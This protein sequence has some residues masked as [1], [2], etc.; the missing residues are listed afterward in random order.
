MSEN[1]ETAKTVSA[2]IRARRSTRHFTGAVPPV[3]DMDE[4]LQSAILAPF[5]GETGIPLKEIRKVFVF[6]QGTQSMN[7]ARELLIGQ[8]RRNS[9]KIGIVLFC[10]P[11]LRKRILPFSR[12]IGMLAK[13]GIPGLREAAYYV[14]LAER[15]G[16]P[17]VE[18][19]SI[20]H[21]MQNMWLT[22]TAQGLGFELISATGIMSKNKR[23]MQLL[24][25]RTGDYVIDGCVIGVPKT[26]PE[27]RE[28]YHAEDFVTWI[29]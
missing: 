28:E 11:F 23:F 22:A 21:A 18:K 12:R 8:V 26:A 2:V 19:Q 1:D 3:E 16:F 10:L 4:I 20:A 25:L 13:E 24:G 9:R 14:I 5:G 29:K 27:P 6:S 7:R 17:P 15:K